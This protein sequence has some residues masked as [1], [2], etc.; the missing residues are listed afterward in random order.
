MSL[1]K[2]PQMLPTHVRVVG[3]VDHPHIADKGQGPSLE[4]LA[5]E[6]FP[7]VVAEIYAEI[8][9]TNGS[10]VPAPK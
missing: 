3:R 4:L 6:P 2:V 7:E 8:N 9:E 5:L 1:V 10:N